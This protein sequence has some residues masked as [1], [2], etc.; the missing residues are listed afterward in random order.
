EVTEDCVPLL[1]AHVAVAGRADCFTR[2]AR[3]K[4]VREGEIAPRITPFVVAR[5]LERRPDRAARRRILP[6]LFAL[7]VTEVSRVG[8][9]QR[10]VFPERP[11]CEVSLVDEVKDEAAFEQRVVEP[12][13]VIARLKLIARPRASRPFAGFVEGDGT[14]RVKHAEVGNRT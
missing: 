5:S 2:N 9:E 1:N 8:D 14:L 10:A 11:R 3:P 13:Q 6:D 4:E 12:L 7:P